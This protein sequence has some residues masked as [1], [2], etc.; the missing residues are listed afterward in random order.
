MKTW[1]K[2]S[3][4]ELNISETEYGLFGNAADGGR[5]G[6]GIISGH[7]KW[8]FDKGGDNTGDNKTETETDKT[9]ENGGGTDLAS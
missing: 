7:S 8:V 6:D 9:P 5:F 4:E 2:A 1:V 3:I